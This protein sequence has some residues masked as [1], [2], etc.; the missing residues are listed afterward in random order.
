MSVLGTSIAASVAQTAL[1]SQQVARQ[2]DGLNSQAAD[3]ARRL[4]DLVEGHLQALE[5]GDE[6]ES[7][8]Q[9]HIDN[10][11]P[12]HQSGG[13]RT[14]ERDT[15]AAPSRDPQAP[16]PAEPPSVSLYRHLDLTA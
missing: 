16:T 13:Y 3:G 10:Q 8:A 9:L 6:F 12:D 1:Q 7:P 14:P 4:R 15:P 2:R 5:E 11:L